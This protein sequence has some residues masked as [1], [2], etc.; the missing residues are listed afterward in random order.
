MASIRI[1]VVDGRLI[2]CFGYTSVNP[3]GTGTGQAQDDP[4]APPRYTLRSSARRGRAY[5]FRTMR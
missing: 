2:A 1:G 5:F 4:A 3:T